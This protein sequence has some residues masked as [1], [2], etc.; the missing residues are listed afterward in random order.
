MFKVLVMCAG[1]V[2]DSEV[3]KTEKAAI[4]YASEQ[5]D[6]GHRVRIIEQL[7]TD[8]VADENDKEFA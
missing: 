1:A 7:D 3:F 4:A 6:F 8:D 2:L 5:Q